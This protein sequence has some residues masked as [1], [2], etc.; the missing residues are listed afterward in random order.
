MMPN[1]NHQPGDH[2]GPVVTSIQEAFNSAAPSIAFQQLLQQQPDL[3]NEV[4]E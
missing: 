1:V 3:I 4:G 2:K